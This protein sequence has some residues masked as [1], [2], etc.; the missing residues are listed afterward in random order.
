MAGQLGESRVRAMNK[1]AL[2]TGASSGLGAEF[3]RQLAAQGYHLVLVARR[4]QRLAE[5]ADA[6]EAKHGI[7][8]QVLV[9]N[10]AH[11]ESMRQVEACIASLPSLEILVNNAGFGTVGSFVEVERGKH[12][13]MIQVHITAPVMLTHAALPGMLIRRKGHIINV[14]SVA[15][16]LPLRSELYSTTKAFLIQF[17]E[18][19]QTKLGG[20][21]V[22]LQAL[23]PGFT[24]TEFHQTS[25][26]TGFRRD[27]IPGFLW[28]SAEQVVRESLIA[29]QRHQ[30]ICIPGG[31]YRLIV[32]LARA[33][34]S[35][36]LIHYVGTHFLR[37]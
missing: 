7:H 24:V 20:S 15:G 27:K 12:D 32:G 34:I 25:E 35:S 14:A 22:Y 18:T 3:A 17:S 5:L 2:I 28:L 8:A 10:L 9:A 1:T 13:A 11:R 31:W 26:Y 30:L 4:E 29:L 33:P 16:I 36:S 23:C 19:L 21:G 6:L 37:K